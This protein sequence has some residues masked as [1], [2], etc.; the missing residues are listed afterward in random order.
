MK[1]REKWEVVIQSKK[2]KKC[3]RTGHWHQ[4]CSRRHVISTVVE[5][6]II[7]YCIKIQNKWTMAIWT[8]MHNRSNQIRRERQA[9]ETLI[10]LHNAC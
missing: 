4:Q 3:L 5:D 2:C 9:Q 1:V 8:L 6:H 7:T 10:E